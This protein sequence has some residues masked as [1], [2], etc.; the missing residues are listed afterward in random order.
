M[1]RDVDFNEISDGKRYGLNDMVKADC[2]DCSGCSSCC[3]GMGTSVVLDPLD[4]WRLKTHLS[5]TFEEL[6]QDKLELQVV[7]GVILPNLNM[8]REGEQCG[9]LDENGR[10]RIHAFRPG[11]CRLFPLGRIYEEQGFWYFLQIHECKKEN[12]AK[13]KVR[14]WLDTPDVKRYERF[15]LDWHTF[16]KKLEARIQDEK[17]QE[18]AQRVSMYVLKEFYILPYEEGEDFYEQLGKRLEAASCL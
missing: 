5:C 6:L 15:V 18:F 12:R 4:V 10:C 8:S 2:K 13:I 3:R 17:S 9:F 11:I 1:K 16:L 7:D 14:K